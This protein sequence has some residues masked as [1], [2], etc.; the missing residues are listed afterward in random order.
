[1]RLIA[2]ANFLT[3]FPPIE[4]IAYLLYLSIIVHY[5]LCNN[6]NYAKNRQSK[7]SKLCCYNQSRRLHGHQKTW[8][9]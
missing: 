6:F 1:M 9:C 8:A 7:A 4:V 2:Y 5:H 3:H